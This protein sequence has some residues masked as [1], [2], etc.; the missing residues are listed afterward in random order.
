MKSLPLGFLVLA[1]AVYSILAGVNISVFI[2]VH[3]LGMVVVG[4]IG[5]FILSNP[6]DEIRGLLE[7]LKHLLKNRDRESKVK[8]SLLSLSRN[9]GLGVDSRH[10]LVIYAQDLWEKGLENELIEGLLIQKIQE[11]EQA[12][13]KAVNTMRNLSKYPPSL[14]MMGTVV[15]LVSLFSHLSTE[16]KEAIGGM[17][18]LAMTATFYGLIIAN[19]IIMPITDRLQINELARTQQN[20][21]VLKILLLIHRNESSKVVEDELNHEAA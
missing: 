11:M 1:G 10:T 4:T 18:A 14:G 16:N 2:N 12:G 7:C 9:R 6:S 8:E 3:A 15:G 17:L 5:V 20:E 13:E 21:R 19:I